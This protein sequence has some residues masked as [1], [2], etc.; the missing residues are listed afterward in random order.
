MKKVYIIWKSFDEDS[1]DEIVDIYS[2]KDKAQAEADKL[3]HEIYCDP[4]NEDDSVDF[5][6][7]GYEVK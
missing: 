7:E 6:V 5:Y 1:H 3:R 4:E 2:D